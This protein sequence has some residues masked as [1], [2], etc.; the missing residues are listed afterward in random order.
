[1]PPSPCV[2]DTDIISFL[3]KGSTQVALYRPHLIGRLL[4]VSFF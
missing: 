2:V 3:F 1:M 4:I